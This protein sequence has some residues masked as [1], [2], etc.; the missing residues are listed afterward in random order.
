MNTRH[1]YIISLILGLYLLSCSVTR[2]N[3]NP[4]RLILT[5]EEIKELIPLL[6]SFTDSGLNFHIL[7]SEKL[8]DSTCMIRVYLNHQLANEKLGVCEILQFN[9]NRI[10]VYD[11]TSCKMNLHDSLTTLNKNVPFLL[12]SPVWNVL[13]KRRSGHI[14][15][16][17]VTF[18]NNEKG[19]ILENL[20]D[21]LH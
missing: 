14:E 8:N 20:S 10:F 1:I 11:S 18:F 5:Q 17:N 7:Y 12:D 2:R 19:E 15:Y 3:N 16:Y 21:S 4:K 6:G 9:K 13:V